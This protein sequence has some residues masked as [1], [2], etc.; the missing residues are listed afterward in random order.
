MGIIGLLRFEHNRLSLQVLQLSQ[1]LLNTIETESEEVSI[2]VVGI[3]KRTPLINER[4]QLFRIV[5]QNLQLRGHLRETTGHIPYFAGVGQIPG[6]FSLLGKVA[7]NMQHLIGKLVQFIVQ[8][9]INLILR[10][11]P[12]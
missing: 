8:C 3:D 2:V 1:D 10:H 5:Q 11:I 6:V 4:L 9:F 12:T 7:G